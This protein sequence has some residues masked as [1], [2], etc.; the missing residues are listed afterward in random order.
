MDVKPCP[1]KVLGKLNLKP[2][3]LK[4]LTTENRNSI[5]CGK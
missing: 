5:S 3:I 1:K 2:N 4:H